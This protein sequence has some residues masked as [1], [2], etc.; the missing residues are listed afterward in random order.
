M[1]KQ[2][3]MK[4]F[5]LLLLA[6]SVLVVSCSPNAEVLEDDFTSKSGEDLATITFQNKKGVI[7]SDGTFDYYI[8]DDFQY[9]VETTYLSELSYTEDLENESATFFAGNESIQFVKTNENGDFS[10]TVI[11][12]GQTFDYDGFNVSNGDLVVKGC[13]LCWAAAAEIVKEIVESLQPSEAENC[14]AAAAKSCGEGQVKT[15]KSVVEEGWFGESIS[16]EFTCK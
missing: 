15:L 2:K 16:C 4:K 6:V 5:N 8:N 3:T 10:V 14:G 9:N 13:P 12:D 1:S 7:K 11:R